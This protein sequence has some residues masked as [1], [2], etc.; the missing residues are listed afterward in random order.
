MGIQLFATYSETG[1]SAHK[2]LFLVIEDDPLLRES[3]TELLKLNGFRIVEAGDGQT[4]IKLAQSLQPDCILLDLRLPDTDGFAVLRRMKKE[5]QTAQIPVVVLSG[6][7]RLEDQELALELGA[8]AY[9][10]KPYNIDEL[11]TQIRRVLE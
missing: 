8:A 3:L 11:V 10:V 4:G 1:S 2:T 9:V 7:S 6:F 5:E